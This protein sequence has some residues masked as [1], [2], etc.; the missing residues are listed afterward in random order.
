MKIT[1]NN[2]ID[3]INKSETATTDL[4]SKYTLE[5]SNTIISKFKQD[6]PQLIKELI[7]ESAN[8]RVRIEKHYNSS[9]QEPDWAVFFILDVKGSDPL[10]FY[11]DD[12]TC[13]FEND[14]YIEGRVIP[15]ASDLCDVV[16]DYE[17]L[18]SREAS[19]EESTEAFEFIE[20]FA[21]NLKHDNI[22]VY[23]KY[24]VQDQ[25]YAY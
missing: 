6:G 12:L 18:S 25:G 19:L 13:G 15:E 5:L 23:Y 14:G 10:F 1:N 8:P 7:S 22:E 9:D 2:T 24:M 11:T 17:M 20:D 3:Q 21:L 16:N 4:Y